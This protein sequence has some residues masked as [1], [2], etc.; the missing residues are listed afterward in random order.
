M[1]SLKFG[2]FGARAGDASDA[3]RGYLIRRLRVAANALQ[4]ANRRYSAARPSRNQSS[5]ELHSA[6]SR[7]CN[8]LSARKTG[9][10]GVVERSAEC[11]SAIQQIKNLRYAC[12]QFGGVE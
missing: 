4:A 5:A 3:G 10:L 1:P 2:H 11:N 12:G 9:R 6:V 8:P 7:I